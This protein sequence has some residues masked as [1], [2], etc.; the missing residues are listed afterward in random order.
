MD[1]L[2]TKLYDILSHDMVLHVRDDIYKTIL[3]YF[4]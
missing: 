3:V 1:P 2:Y 4:S